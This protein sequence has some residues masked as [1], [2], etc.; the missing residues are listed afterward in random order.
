MGVVTESLVQLI[1][2]QVD[3]RGLV[4]WYDPEQAYGA[5]AAELSLP[6]TTVAR[7]DGSF[8]KLRK[9]IDHLLNDGQ[10]PRLLV[11]VP[12]ERTETNSAL[13][14]LDC[15]GVIMQPR[16]QPPACNTRLSV[17]GRNALRPIL[18]GGSG[19]RDR[20]AGRV[21]QVLAGR[22]EFISRTGNRYFDRRLEAHLRHS[23]NPQEVALAFLHGDH[24]DEE[25]GQERS[26]EGAYVS[27]SRLA[28]TSNFP[29]PRP[30]GNW[31][32][33][34][35]AARLGDGSVRRPQE[36]SAIIAIV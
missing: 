22:P 18:G 16:Q 1:A 10:A 34:V 35:G 20:T 9:E 4:V 27:Y 7:Y 28:S 14:E 5:V 15:A 25:I 2:K 26:G 3:D 30:W 21:A 8:L 17:V 31:S 24:Y 19:S 33:P 12:I 11:Y 13:I 32:G 6:N 36:A 29:L 23:A